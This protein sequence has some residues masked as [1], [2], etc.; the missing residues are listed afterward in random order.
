MISVEI[1]TKLMVSGEMNLTCITVMSQCDQ[2][3]AT[4]VN[5]WPLCH[6]L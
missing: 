4:V 6:G 2:Y 5:H 1:L 3:V